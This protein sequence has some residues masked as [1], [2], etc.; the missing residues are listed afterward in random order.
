MEIKIRPNEII[1]MFQEA[2]FKN[3]IFEQYGTMNL[4]LKWK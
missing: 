1:K 2:G 4:F 3:V